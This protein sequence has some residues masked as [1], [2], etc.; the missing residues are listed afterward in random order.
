MMTNLTIYDPASLGC[1][2][3]RLE[4]WVLNRN[5]FKEMHDEAGTSLTGAGGT[6]MKKSVGHAEALVGFGRLHLHG[7]RAIYPIHGTHHRTHR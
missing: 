2:G 6:F 4:L 7:I 3:S 1:L 5:V